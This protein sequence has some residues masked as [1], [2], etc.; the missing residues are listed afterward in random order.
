VLAR[1]V[2]VAA[3]IDYES[4]QEAEMWRGALTAALDATEADAFALAGEV[5]AP[6]SVLLSA[7][8]GLRAALARDLN[9]VIG[10]LPSVRLVTP[11]GT[12]STW[13]LA[14]HF[15]GDDPTAVVAM[16][17]DIVARNRLPHAGALPPEPVEVLV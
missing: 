15:A 10:R 17:D 7:T 2:E 11:A 12:V 8:G 13:L 16:F 9:E 5:P 6:A 4:R 3:G 1:A 14:Q